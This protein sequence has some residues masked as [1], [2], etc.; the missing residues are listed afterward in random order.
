MHKNTKIYQNLFFMILGIFIFL[1]LFYIF[2][3]KIKERFA[4][5]S[6][7]YA[8]DLS[9][10]GYVATRLGDAFASD[11]RDSNV[12]KLANITNNRMMK[13]SG[14][15]TDE[16]VNLCASNCSNM[17]SYGRKCDGFVLEYNGSNP[18]NPV[19]SCWLKSGKTGLS[20]SQQRLA[21]FLNFAPVPDLSSVGYKASGLGDAFSSDITD[22]NILQKAGLTSFYKPNLGLTTNDF[23]TSCASSCDMMN[24]SE[25]MC[26]NSNMNRNCDGFV[27]N[28]NGSNTVNP[29]SGCWLKTGPTGLNS[30]QDR[31]AYFWNGVK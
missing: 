30:S 10:Q 2:S 31:I 28:Y 17:N 1:V 7:A 27:L 26:P 29:V 9:L 24:V 25:Y 16:F 8:P 21:Y 11:I 4:N 14:M 23:V 5:L 18:S 15:G 6:F 19:N 13:S 20:G 22:K 12:L 3:S